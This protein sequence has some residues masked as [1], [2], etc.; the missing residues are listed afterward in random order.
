MTGIAL[1]RSILQAPGLGLVSAACDD[2]QA[3]WHDVDE[4]VRRLAPWFNRLDTRLDMYHQYAGSIAEGTK[5]GQLDEFDIQLCIKSLE[6]RSAVYHQEKWTHM[7]DVMLTGNKNMAPDWREFLTEDKILRPEKLYSHLLKL[8]CLVLIKEE[9]Y[10]GLKFYYKHF[11][12]QNRQLFLIWAPTG[13]VI[14]FDLAF[15]VKMPEWVPPNSR[16]DS[17]LLH[18]HSV[19]DSCHLMLF[20]GKR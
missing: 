13:L 18:G 17:P 15:M 5:V 10:H 3:I 11:N 7:V 8:L 14:K 16:K 1:M 19:Q 2:N 20:P 12:L 4:L 6:G 9:L